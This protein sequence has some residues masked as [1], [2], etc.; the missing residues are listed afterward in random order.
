MKYKHLH[1]SN[2]ELN[3]KFKHDRKLA[4]TLGVKASQYNDIIFTTPDCIPPNHQW[5]ASMQAMFAKHPDFVIGHCNYL[6]ASKLVRCDNIYT[7][8]F[9]ISAARKGFPFKV[10]FKNLGISK[11]M[12]LNNKGFA[13]INHFPNS[14]ETLFVCRNATAKNTVVALSKNNIMMSSQRL[15]FKHWWW[16]RVTQAS[17]FAMGKRGQSLHHFEMFSRILFYL[18]EIALATLAIL[19]YDT[20]IAIMI[21]PLILI[22]LLLQM[23]VFQRIRIV[24]KEN[25]IMLSLFLYD[26]WSPIL[27]LF[28]ALLRPDLRKIKTIKSK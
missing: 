11:K 4:I 1:Y 17:L 24:W 15:A 16:Q 6:N 23:I 5:L 22:R 27:A 14:E 19:N 10:T 8:L 2:V 13:N 20:L 21:V 12:F 18:S 25:N 26:R 7:S 28:I 9:A 3:E